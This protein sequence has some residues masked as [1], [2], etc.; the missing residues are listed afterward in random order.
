MSNIWFKMMALEFKVR[1]YLHPR[2][3]IVN[4]IGLKPGLQV[5]DF[6]C[7]PGGYVLAVSQAIGPTGKLY[8]LDALPV[9]VNMVNN[10]AAKKGLTN[11]KTILSECDTSLED[12]QLDVALLY[13]VF[14]DLE[15]Q[16]AVLTEI[17]R[18]LNSNGV[19]SFSDHHLKDDEIISKIT[20]TG[21]FKLQKKGKYTY[22]FGKQ[23]AAK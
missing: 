23:T 2:Q 11:L 12:R 19:L 22:N 18:V 10:I 7:G 4:E 6:G 21:L 5:L 1:D 14:H 3:E 15:N 9:A 8:A 13:D 17:D 20:G 16:N